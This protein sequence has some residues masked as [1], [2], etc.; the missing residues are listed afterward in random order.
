MDTKLEKLLNHIGINEDY[1]NYFKDAFIDKV[2]VNK[3]TGNISFLI[4]IDVIPPYRV[5]KKY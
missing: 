4:K 1:I 2:I 3:K 5:Y